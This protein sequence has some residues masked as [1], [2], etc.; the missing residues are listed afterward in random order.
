MESDLNH[1][2]CISGVVGS[3]S[4]FFF[5][6]ELKEKGRELKGR[7]GQL[8]LYYIERRQWQERAC[9]AGSVFHFLLV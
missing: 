2:E 8:R 5:V 4:V 1:H 9:R 6:S 3:S 7:S